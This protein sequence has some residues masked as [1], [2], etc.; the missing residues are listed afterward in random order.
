M[1]DFP[2]E[3]PG[4]YKVIPMKAFRRTPGVDFHI[5]TKESIPRID[6][7]DRVIHRTAAVSPGPVGEISRPWY[8]HPHQDDNL[9]VLSGERLI[10]IYHLP[11]R[12]FLTFRVTPDEIYS[13]EKCIYSE[14]AILVWPCGVFHRIVSGIDGSASLNL[15]TRYDGFDISTNFSIYSLDQTAGL[16]EEI[17]KGELDQM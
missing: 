1:D 13:G 14:P 16:Y 9:I 6:G 3:I 4:F 15:A 12:T 8:M 5:M 10:D 7:V 11:T 2:P 17:R